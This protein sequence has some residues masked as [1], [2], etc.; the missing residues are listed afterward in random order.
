[1]IGKVFQA[2][3]F[4]RQSQLAQRSTML[5]RLGTRTGLSLAPRIAIAA[6]CSTARRSESG[7]PEI[8]RLL[9]HLLNRSISIDCRAST[10]RA[11]GICLRDGKGKTPVSPIQYPSDE[12]NRLL[13]FFS[14]I[15]FGPTLSTMRV[16]ISLPFRAQIA[17]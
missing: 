2:F 6:H 4:T 16:D 11:F 3:R 7:H 12:R 14:R 15:T 17:T 5:G 8:S 1:M 9:G 13:S 10:W